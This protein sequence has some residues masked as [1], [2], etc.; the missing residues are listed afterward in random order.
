MVAKLKGPVEEVGLIKDLAEVVRLVG[1]SLVALGSIATQED[2][3]W[4]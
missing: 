4:I 1:S 3:R 2:G